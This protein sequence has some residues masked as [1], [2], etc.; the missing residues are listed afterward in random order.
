M[1]SLLILSLLQRPASTGTLIPSSRYLADT[2]ARQALG[3][4]LVVELGA[5]TGPVT[6]A[7]L[8]ACP[9]TPIVVVEMQD[10]LAHH[11]RRQFPTLDVRQTTA[12][13]AL[14]TLADA[15]AR[16]TLVSSLP[17]RS[18][19]PDV[20]RNTRQ[21]IARFL[22]ADPARKLVQFTYQPRAPFRA[23]EGLAWHFVGTVWRNAPPAG[24]W[25]L[26]AA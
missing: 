23:P 19:P 20:A 22:L 3:A 25:T 17:F 8:A 6:E 18:L 9:Q 2:M 14:E 13:S 11:L 16:T 10:R 15:P 12:E 24:V 1:S 4:E 5:G 26:Q 21:S 7:L